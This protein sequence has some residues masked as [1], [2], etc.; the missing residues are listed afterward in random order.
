MTCP[1]CNGP[2]EW[3]GSLARGKMACAQCDPDESQLVWI[4]IHGRVSP[5]M[6]R[7]Y[8]EV[9][10]WHRDWCRSRKM[11]NTRKGQATDPQYCDCGHQQQTPYSEYEIGQRETATYGM[12][13]A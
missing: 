9:D 10:A 1:K 7:Y 11:A 6:A 3:R 5:T 4:P 13:I 2:T 8:R 12:A